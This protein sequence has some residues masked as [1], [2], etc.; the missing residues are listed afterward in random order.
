VRKTPLARQVVNYRII[1]HALHTAGSRRAFRDSAAGA[2][3]PVIPESF[4][5]PLDQLTTRKIDI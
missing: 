4:G 2:A 1:N 5:E 3:E